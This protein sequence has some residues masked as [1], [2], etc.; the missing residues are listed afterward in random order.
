MVLSDSR[1]AAQTERQTMILKVEDS[2]YPYGWTFFDGVHQPSVSG[3]CPFIGVTAAN[4]SISFL[5]DDDELTGKVDA[6][7][8]AFSVLHW[9]V[10]KDEAQDKNDRNRWLAVQWHD[11]PETHVLVTRRS[12]F[13]MSEDGKTVERL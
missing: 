6:P 3:R 5:A 7:Q 2:T 8:W 12:A 11:G 1:N 10:G 13:L 4:D 9:M